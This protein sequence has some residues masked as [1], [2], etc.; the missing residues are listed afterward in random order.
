M[1]EEFA[2]VDI[3]QTE[4]WNK[5]ELKTSESIGTK[6]EDCKFAEIR[7]AARKKDKLMCALTVILLVVFS[8]A[9][10]VVTMHL[11]GIYKL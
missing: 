9:V 6:E 10:V 8:L 2:L 1:S 5:F 11:K 3:L 4:D 7:K